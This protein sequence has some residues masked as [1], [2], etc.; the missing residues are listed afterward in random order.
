MKPWERMVF[1]LA[2]LTV[3][4]AIGIKL[5]E[6]DMPVARFVRSFDIGVLNLVGD[7]LALPGKGVVVTGAFILIGLLGWRGQRNQLAPMTFS[8]AGL[9]DWVSDWWRQRNQLTEI[10][11]RGLLAQL[12]ITAATQLLK[13]LIGRPRPRFAHSDEFSLGPSLTTGF[14][15]FPSGHAANAFGAATVL[16][17]FFPAVRV[18]LYLVAG[19]VA[20][21]RVLRGSHFPTDVLAGAVLGVVIGSAVVVGLKRWPEDALPGLLRTGVPV[22]VST[23][24]MLWVVL[25][26]APA[27]SYE[28]ISLG[29]GVALVLAG[30]FVRGLSWTYLEGEDK[31]PLR[32]VGRL[33]LI[34][35]VAVGC[36]PWWAAVLLGVALVP[37]GLAGF[38][39]A[40]T[41]ATALPRALA[42]VP[43][44][45]REALAV[46]AALLV[47]AALQSVQGLLPLR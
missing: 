32:T 26:P 4:A 25:H 39:Q 24:A 21:S 41:P 9:V 5:H 19:L 20:V 10:G 15:S 27:R 31:G 16:A 22:A 8:M 38:R 30:G 34:V 35:G 6:L 23:F 17:W 1:G 7:L 13:H 18:P 36:A 44:W 45:G 12:G 28:I 37:R 14:D 43:V 2:A 47:L 46:G 42:E 11:V 33:L 29:V 3:L 40:H